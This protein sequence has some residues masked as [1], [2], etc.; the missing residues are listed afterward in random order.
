MNFL[1][2][3]ALLIIGATAHNFGSSGP[4]SYGA[5]RGGPPHGAG[6]RPPHRG[7]KLFWS[8]RPSPGSSVMR[9]KLLKPNYT[10]NLKFRVVYQAENV[11]LQNANST[12]PIKE[13]E[14]IFLL[15]CVPQ[16]PPPKDGRK[17]PERLMSYVK[18]TYKSNST[19]PLSFEYGV[20]QGLQPF[21]MFGSG[22]HEY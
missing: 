22:S 11:T 1:F 14:T 21:M 13:G 18:I 19:T 9:G 15:P 5:Q 16:G 17:P 6:R 12:L 20:I 3:V 7:G 8:H 4:S 2:V 10:N